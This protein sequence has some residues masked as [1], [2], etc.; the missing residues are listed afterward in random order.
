[1]KFKFI[2]LFYFTIIAF[3][4]TAQTGN[5]IVFEKQSYDFGTFSEDGENQTCDFK[6]TNQGDR[7]IAITHV[8]TTC[9]CTVAKYTR[10]PI[11]PGKGGT[12]SVTY[13]PQGRPGKFNRSILVDITGSNAKIKLTISGIVT[14]GAQRK[15]K[16][17]PYV[18]GSM[19]LKT[20]RVRFSPMRGNEQEQNIVIVN[21][22]KEPIRLQF[23]SLDT[24]LSG[25]TV[26]RVISPDSIGEIRV[27][28][29]ADATKM[30]AKCIR[31]KEDK[32]YLSKIG[33]IYIE[34]ATE[35][36]KH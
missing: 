8:Q 13:N 28:R 24:T 22:G 20:T 26:P 7:A 33:Y 18:M 30:Q 34:I 25:Y 31:L 15:D 35:K 17:F 3:A 19:Q 9:G 27:C 11:Q 23:R 14:P 32:T 29:K 12:I 1:M 21:S 6:F 5:N 36:C 4:A 16:R 2:I 10:A